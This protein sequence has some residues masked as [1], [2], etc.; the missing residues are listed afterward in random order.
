MKRIFYLA[1][2]V[3]SI[4]SCKKTNTIPTE[5]ND[6]V[7]VETNNYQNNQNAVL[8]YRDNGNGKLEQLAGS[9][10]LTNGAGVSNL[11]QV[12]GPLDSDYELRV[13]SDGQ[14]L[15]A[16]NSGSN[17]IAVF[18]IK[19]NGAL[20]PVAGSPFPSGGQ[21]P[22]SIDVSGNNV[23]VVNKSNDPMQATPLAPNYTT[24]TID[25]SG[26][27]TPV[28][29]GKFETT[30]GTS[31]SQALVSRDK[32]F[33]FGSDFLGIMLNPPVGTLRSFTIAGTGVLTPVVG[34]PYV[35]PNSATAPDNAA[36]G[37]WQHPSGNPL[38]VGIPLQ[39]KIGV[40][41]V[42]AATGA[43]T[44][45]STVA[46]GKAVCWI[47][48]NKAG[49]HLYAL[50][51]ADNA[52]QVYDT[53]NPMSPSSVQTL[54]LKNSGPAYG[55]AAFKTSQAFSLAFSS[56]EKILYVV[57]QHTNTDFSIGNFN[58]LHALTVADNGMLTEN[59]EPIQLPVANTIRPKGTAVVNR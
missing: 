17:T 34:S 2:T 25:G 8:A 21:T 18:S 11:G 46:A 37:L 32:K 55:D 49:D 12:L 42:N 39:G 10:F 6:I 33:L 56:T 38:Y 5:K 58:Y 44:L 53:S 29:G 54:E 35:L 43:L 51:S 19:P 3:L 16:V 57:S 9:P 45:Q 47:R 36:L 41:N 28:A 52:V 23:F 22:V 24:F 1:I 31:P 26:T 27:L 40:F 50:N 20:Q 59:T 30:P 7:Y 14:F 48:T 13:S 15:L 4:V